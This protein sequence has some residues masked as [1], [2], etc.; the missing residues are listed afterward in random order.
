MIE[1]IKYKGRKYVLKSFIKAE[2]IENESKKIQALNE[3]DLLKETS[4]PGLNKL[5]T[6]TKDDQRVCLVL[7]LAEGV[8]MARL[9]KA[10]IPLTEEFVAII[11]A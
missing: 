5:V 6:T 2:L 11:V 1:L 10:N 4:F 9:I 3:R 7:E 8:D